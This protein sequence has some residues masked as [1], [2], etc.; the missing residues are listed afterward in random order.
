MHCNMKK[1][2]DTVLGYNANYPLTLVI[3]LY[4]K[5]HMINSEFDCRSGK[6][7]KCEQNLNILF[8]GQKTLDIENK[9][10]NLR[11]Y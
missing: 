3:L 10:N 9:D 2:P 8:S 11:V 1:V 6:M 7:F 5:K 4:K